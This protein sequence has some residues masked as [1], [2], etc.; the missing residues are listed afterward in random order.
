VTTVDGYAPSSSAGTVWV[1]P[2]TR[3]AAILHAAREVLVA[4][5]ITT[6]EQTAVQAA[7]DS[8]AA[9][10]TR[11]GTTSTWS[12]WGVRVVAL[13]ACVDLLAVLAAR[14]RTDGPLTLAW[15]GV[16]VAAVFVVGNCMDL[17]R[18]HL[19]LSTL[20]DLPAQL[21]AGLF[22]VL[23][24]IAAAGLSGRPAPS[25]RWCLA[26]G[27]ACVIFLAAGRAC[28]YATIRRLRRSGRLIRPM[29][30]IGSG[31]VGQRLGSILLAHPEY[32]LAP[33]G[34]VDSGARAAGPARSALPLLGGLDALPDV[35]RRLDARDVVFAFGAAPDALLVGVVRACVASDMRVFVVPRYFEFRGADRRA[36]TEMVWGVPLVRLR[37]WPLR[38]SR[39]T[40]KRV[41]DVVLAG[42]GLL[43][44]SP[45]MAMCALVARLDGGPG[46]VFRQVRVGRDGRMFTLLKFR[47]MRPA[48][49][50]GD[51][52]WSIDGDERISRFGRFLRRTSL[53]ELPQ[54]INVLRGDMS[55][56]GPRPERPYF[57]Q[58]FAERFHRYSDRLRTAGGL[59]GWAQ[60]N[61]LRGNTP[62]DD[63]V[64]FDNYYI[65]NW[66]LW[67]DIKIILRT[68]PSML[69]RMH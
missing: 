23:A 41:L 59:T 53:D 40:A 68:V 22:A 55:I 7:E 27:A 38:P 20:D 21:L 58:H 24:A 44:L 62:I 42:L 63:R 57:V 25:A 11:R 30:I 33:V 34:F 17:Y 16:P 12:S 29:V 51:R 61:G 3:N 43:V 49:D 15:L 45:V 64:T 54:L 13:F 32:G 60:V 52:R 56:V 1:A 37:R 47:S 28:V 14:W 10:A 4:L 69:R 9:A 36:R 19:E 67:S 39:A 18:S 31:D 66:S 6:K 50:E 5:L 35:L 46:V 48:G 26:F 65:D 2:N 8:G